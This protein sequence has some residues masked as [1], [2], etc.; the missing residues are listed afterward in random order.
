[1]DRIHHRAACPPSYAF[2][3]TRTFDERIKRN[4]PVADVHQFRALAASQAIAP[5]FLN[6]SVTLGNPSKAI[7]TDSGVSS[8]LTANPSYVKR[9]E[10]RIISGCHYRARF[11]ERIEATDRVP[12]SVVSNGN[13]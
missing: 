5:A 8:P 1:V 7:R 9:N 3:S 13:A 10:P 12:C 4:T 11:V 6:Q 2:Q